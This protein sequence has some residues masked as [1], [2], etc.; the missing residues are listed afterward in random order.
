MEIQLAKSV[1]FDIE[2]CEQLK[3]RTGKRL[4]RA[5]GISKD[6]DQVPI[7]GLS[8]RVKGGV[9]A[10]AIMK[11]IQPMLVSNGYRAFWSTRRGADGS[12]QC[13]EVAVLQTTD[14]FAIVKVQRTD[15]A[16]YN[17][18]HRAVLARLG[19]WK[20]RCTFEVVGASQDWVALMFQT[21]PKD[22]CTFAAEVYRFCPDTVNQGVGLIRE[23]EH[24]HEFAAARRLCPQLSPRIQRHLEN[25]KNKLTRQFQD[26]PRWRAVMEAFKKL[27]RSFEEPSTEMGIKLLAYELKKTKYLFLWWD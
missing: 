21:L 26:D 22:L 3:A 12:R 7:D 2:I 8:M 15:G 13:D 19:R 6:L 4:E 10:E 23:S 20:K 9:E 18:T 5:T 17:V 1:S 27:P 24:A 16:N 25:E 11:K 14:P